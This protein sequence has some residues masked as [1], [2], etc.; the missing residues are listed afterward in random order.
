ML[1]HICMKV[2]SKLPFK[3]DTDQVQLLS[4]LTYVF[5]SYCS[6]FKIT[7]SLGFQ[8]TCMNEIGRELP[9]EELQISS[10]FVEVYL[11]NHLL[12]F[13]KKSFSTLLLHI[14]FETSSNEIKTLVMDV[15][16]LAGLLKS[17]SE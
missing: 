6:L 16:I 2:G 7:S 11:L 13:L 4:R 3:R 15:V 12:P 9:Y 1:S 14:K 5:M 17:A 10:T 8:I